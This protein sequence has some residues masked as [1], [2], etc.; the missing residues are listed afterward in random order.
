VLAPISDGKIIIQGEQTDESMEVLASADLFARVEANDDGVAMNIHVHML[1]NQPPRLVS[2]EVDTS[3]PNEQYVRTTS[4]KV[5][6]TK[7]LHHI[8]YLNHHLHSNWI[9]LIDTY[10]ECSKIKS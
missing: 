6:L 2:F 1:A 5:Q 3:P 4:D 7:L 8:N 10:N 9:L